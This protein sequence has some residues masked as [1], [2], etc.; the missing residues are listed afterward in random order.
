MKTILS[1]ACALIL[2]GAGASAQTLDDLKK[3]GNGGSSDNVL[4]YGMGYHQQRYSPLKQVNKQTVKRLVP[5]WNLSL[6][7]N[8]GEQAQPI[9]YNGVMY[10]TNA[11]ATVAIDVST[12]KQI[13][14]QTLDWPPE[15]PRVV[16]CGVSNK[17]AA[18]YN[19]KVFRTTLD[20]HVVAYDAKDGKELW[21]SKAAEWKDGY[22]LTLAP[23]IANGVLVTGISGA[24]F[25]IRG[26]I[27]GWDT[28]SG[29]H[30]WRRYTIPA[31]G[32][33]GNDTW[34]QDTNAWE[35]GGGS[36]WIT[37][38]YDPD[39]DLMFWGIGN[40]APWASQSRPGDNLYT[41]AVLALR[42]KTGEIVWHYQ[43]TPN[44]AYDYDAC[45]ELIN[46]EI[47]V[48]GQKH[49][50]IM[51]FNRNGFLYVIDRADGKLVAAN[52]FEKVNWASQIDKETGRPTETDVAKKLREGGN[53]VELWPSPLGAKNWPHA[54]YSP[55]TGLLY[56][57][58]QS[59]A[60]MYKHLETKPFVVGQRYMF[61]ENLPMPKQPGEAWG[62]IDAVDPLTGKQKWRVPLTDHAIWSA[63]LVTGGGLLFTGKETGEFIALD[64]ED[65]KQVW[66]FQ[67]GS[68][69]NAQPITYTHNGRQYVTILS[70]IG[71]L[72]WNLAREQLKDKVPQ[73]GSV[74][75]FALLPD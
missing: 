68:G 39:L 35:V 11:R 15:T 2:L 31:R 18:I 19:G 59:Q 29:K 67:T 71:G 41:S 30:L 37:G 74:W 20:A 16:C 50:V 58:T 10:V 7:N 48:G 32:E 1:T 46:A 3:D 26:F 56:A 4:T 21:K 42:P 40:P 6:D 55:E 70:G 63:N 69:I 17:G 64:I 51:Q 52:P 53:A 47:T 12:G 33:K 65:G 75:T 27:D 9:V 5:V 36:A 66:T 28:D 22:S 44:D 38:S 57:N 25:G 8:W 60:R 54:A 14:K 49:K 24:E 23:L 62:H 45:W 34:P 43:F 61:V 73:G 13:W 72:W